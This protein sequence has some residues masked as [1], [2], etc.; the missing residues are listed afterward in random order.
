MTG[1]AR[2][3]LFMLCNAQNREDLATCWKVIAACAAAFP[4]RKGDHWAGV[5][6]TF[7]QRC[8]ELGLNWKGQK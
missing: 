3:C 6:Q 2:V 1:P 5:K 4:D 7:K 8:A